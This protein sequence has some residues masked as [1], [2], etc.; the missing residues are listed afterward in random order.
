VALPPPRVL[1]I[2]FTGGDHPVVA[3][4]SYRTGKPWGSKKQKL[5][6]ELQAAF[7]ERYAQL[8][9]RGAA[10]S[11]D[12]RL[13][14]LVG[15]LEADLNNGGFDQYLRNKGEERGRDAL[16]ALSAI[17]ARRTGRWLAAALAAG[18]GATALGRLDEQFNEKP[19]DLASLVMTAIGHTATPRTRRPA[20]AR[21]RRRR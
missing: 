7:Y 10:L 8:A 16:A 18:P 2:W 5:A 14:E 15:E 17:G 13:I 21:D 4:V 20:G 12:E 3:A 6:A 11:P 19:E 9:A 1:E